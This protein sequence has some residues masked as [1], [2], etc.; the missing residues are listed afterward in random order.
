MKV[1]WRWAGNNWQSRERPREDLRGRVHFRWG[2][3]HSKSL[4]AFRQ[5]ASHTWEGSKDQRCWRT[6]TGKTVM[7]HVGQVGRSW[8]TADLA[9]QN[10]DFDLYAGMKSFR[11]SWWF[12][13]RMAPLK[14]T[15]PTDWRISWRWV[16]RRLGD[17]RKRWWKS[18]WPEILVL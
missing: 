12:L 11:V 10:T 6:S 3:L 5:W 16:R 7:R 9:T 8:A 14:I 4:E 15:P 2:K 18:S 13:I 1:G 17:G